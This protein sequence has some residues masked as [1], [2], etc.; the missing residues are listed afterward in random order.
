MPT[1]VTVLPGDG[2]GPE[3]VAAACE[4]L[5]ATGVGL[6]WEHHHVGAAAVAE[7]G[8]ALPDSVLESVRRN[9]VALK[10]PVA[11][12]REAGFRSVNVA[13]RR[14]L[15]LYVQVRPN[16]SWP[17]LTGT[18][19]GVDLH[20][21]R[22]TTEDLYAGHELAAHHPDTVELLQWLAAR[23]IELPAGTAVS[24]KPTTYEA[25]A[26]AARFALEH[27]VAVGAGRVTFVHKA[28]VMRSTDGLFLAAARDVARDYE[29]VVEVDDLSVDAAAAALV[30]QPQ[31]FGLLFMPNMYG[32]VLS[33]LAAALV[34][35]IGMAPGANYGDGVAVFEAVHGT[36]PRRAG[37]GTANPLGVLLSGVLM[38]RY[39]GEVGAAD[40]VDRAV[41]AVLADGRALTADLRHRDDPRPPVSTGA[42]TEA[43]LVALADA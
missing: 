35:G 20:V 8:S 23:G 12:P 5:D 16:R 39:L 13:L 25:S 15:D 10:G 36:A 26:R 4:V 24:L 14:A 9:R 33:D 31:S 32:D 22:E 30:R 21:V 41:T 18:S 37:A 3:V 43:L 40:R 6:Q 2:I 11:T 34:G 17:A 1:A 38:L 27:A 28:A 42:M 19:P 29:T 7:S